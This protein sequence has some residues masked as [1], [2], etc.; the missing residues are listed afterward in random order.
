MEKIAL[1]AAWGNRRIHVWSV[2]CGVWSVVLHVWSVGFASC[3]K[4]YAKKEKSG[5]NSSYRCLG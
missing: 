1:I 4:M 2:E 5:E 3:K